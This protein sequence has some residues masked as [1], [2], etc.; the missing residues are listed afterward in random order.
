M[1]SRM[2]FLVLALSAFTVSQ[3]GL[4]IRKLRFR[5]NLRLNQAAGISKPLK[6]VRAGTVV[7][8]LGS[9]LFAATIAG[10]GAGRNN[11]WCT[12]TI[13]ATPTADATQPTSTAQSIHVAQPAAPP[14][15]IARREE[16]HIGHGLS[17]D[18]SSEPQLK[19]VGSRRRR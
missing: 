10:T 5:V 15:A 8:T 18:M 3:F 13:T 2:S 9:A 19:V 7:V 1:L 14:G 16:R 11:H 12:I 6:E 4:R 17:V